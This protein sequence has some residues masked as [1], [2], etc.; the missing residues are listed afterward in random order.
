[1]SSRVGRGIALPFLYRGIRRGWVV[2]STPQTALYPRERPGTHFT[3]GWVGPRASLDSGKSCPTG[4][5]SR[6]VQ[7]V[8]SRYTDWAIRPTS[9]RKA[10]KFLPIYTASYSIRQYFSS[11]DFFGEIKAIFTFQMHVRAE[12]KNWICGPRNKPPNCCAMFHFTCIFISY[13]SPLLFVPSFWHARGF[14]QLSA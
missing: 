1:M 7:P 2:S 14:I 4:I 3:G 11:C 9:T 8:I 13:F 5:R 10:G 12:N 6:T